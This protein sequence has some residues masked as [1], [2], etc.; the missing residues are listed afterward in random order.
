MARSSTWLTTPS[1][2]HADLRGLRYVR[3]LVRRGIGRLWTM[4]VHI[5]GLLD[6]Q[7][8][9]ALQPTATPLRGLSAVSL[10]VKR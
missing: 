3:S 2:R 10:V 5:A 7:W 9:K 6:N 1:G 8:L 4:I